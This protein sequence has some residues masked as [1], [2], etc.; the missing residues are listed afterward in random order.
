MYWSSTRNIPAPAPGWL[1]NCG[2]VTPDQH[3][4]TASSQYLNQF[5]VKMIG[6]NPQY[7]FIEGANDMLIKIFIDFV[8][9][10]GASELLDVSNTAVHIARN[11]WHT[12]W[13]SLYDW[14]R[15]KH[16]IAY[17]RRVTKIGFRWYLEHWGRDKIAAIPQATFSNTLFL[18]K[19]YVFRLRFDWRLF[20]RFE[21]TLS[22]HWFK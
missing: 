15:Y 3:W 18:T 19:M 4:L 22:Q 20:Q 11:W 2:L 16:H 8:H 17:S 10:P 5:W 9:L 21:L 1:T 14:V 6:V 13:V 7:D 12:I